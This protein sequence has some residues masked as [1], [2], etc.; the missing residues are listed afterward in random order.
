MRALLLQIYM[1]GGA[2]VS[3]NESK[4]IV[5][6]FAMTLTLAGCGLDPFSQLISNKLRDGSGSGTTAPLCP[7]ALSTSSILGMQ[8]LG[9][10]QS[11]D[12]HKK[13]HLGRSSSLGTFDAQRKI[14]VGTRLVATLDESCSSRIYEEFILTE[15]KNLDELELEAQSD[16]CILKIAENF[17]YKINMTSND[18][19]ISQQG[20]FSALRAFTSYDTFYDANNGITNNVVVAI[21]DSGVDIDHQDLRPNIWRNIDETPN[22]GVDDDQNGYIDDVEGWN[23]AAHGNQAP[24]DPRPLTWTD[25]PGDEVHGTHVAGLAAGAWNNNMGG[26]GIMGRNVKIMALN[27]F[28]DSSSGST[29]RLNQAIRYAA[30]NGA[31]VINL[32]LG[33]CG[34]DQTTFDTILYAICKGSLVVTAAGNTFYINNGVITGRELSD[35]QSDAN[36]DC[37]PTATPS[38]G[39]QKFFQTPASFGSSINGLITVASSDAVPDALN[40]Y[41]KSDFSAWSATTVEIAAPGSQSGTRG[42]YSTLPSNSYGRQEGTSMSSPVVA[43]AAALAKAYSLRKGVTLTPMNLERLIETGG[44]QEVL[45]NGLVKGSKHLDLVNLANEIENNINSYR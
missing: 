43:G 21:V 35:N 27:I 37:N 4:K 31:D 23:F 33:A 19:A 32:S 6:L 44:R 25:S 36:N 39:A 42:L 41:S 2:R 38:T 40:R 13:V 5:A 29:S 12:D 1:R 8:T 11:L 45:L 7:Q 34:L 28:G 22:N 24:N 3:R 10:S 15:E 17:I 14:K 26:A 18:P 20:Q 30:D 16:P 9:L